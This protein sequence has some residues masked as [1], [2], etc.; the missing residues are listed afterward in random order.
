MTLL[1]VVVPVYRTPTLAQRCLDSLLHQPHA[2]IQVLAVDDCSPD[3]TGH[4]LDRYAARDPRVTVLHL[5]ER[6]GPGPARNA[7]LAHVSG[8]YVWFVDGDDEVAPDCLPDIVERLTAT[9]PD[10]L[11]VDHARLCGDRR[12]VR[13]GMNRILREAPTVFRASEYPEV[14]RLAPRAWNKVV[15][16]HF[17]TGWNLR[18][19]TGYYE[20]IPVAYPLL[21]GA[22]RISALDRV[23]VLHRQRRCTYVQRA[24][25]PQHLELLGQYELAFQRLIALGDRA[26]PLLP[27][28]FDRAVRQLLT[29]LDRD[30]IGDGFRRPYFQQ[31]GKLCSLYQPA[32]YHGPRGA[33]D[34]L[35]YR[36]LAQG[37]WPMYHRLWRAHKLLR[38]VRPALH[39]PWHGGPAGPGYGG[40]QHPVGRRHR[41]APGA[42]TAALPT[43][44]CPGT[45]RA[46]DVEEGWRRPRVR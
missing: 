6:V 41:I 39:W 36:L 22:D 38:T 3:G 18:F 21:A 10:V 4:V 43:L 19:P 29:M 34:R 45:G 13:H 14:M 25:G 37:S 33:L 44:M 17:L 24:W 12:I 30:G 40:H 28:V 20:D 27:I 23:C 35:R 42:V 11:V 26:E 31:A 9:R 46:V 16:R 15:R 32:G 7:G 5:P 2:D 8:E 1:S